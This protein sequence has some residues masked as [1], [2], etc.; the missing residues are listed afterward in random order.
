MARVRTFI[1]LLARTL[2]LAHCVLGEEK[3]TNV[4]K[5]QC[6]GLCLDPSVLQKGSELDGEKEALNKDEVIPS[7]T[8]SNNFINYC[9]GKTLTN[10]TKINEGSCN[11]IP[12]GEIPSTKH[13]VST[14]I[15]SPLPGDEFKVN[16]TIT[17][18]V[19]VKNIEMGFYTNSNVSFL[20]APQSLNC[21]GFVRGHTHLTVQFMGLNT[22]AIQAL[23]ASNPTW[24]KS[25]NG[26]H[27]ENK[28][29]DF[30]ATLEGGL[31]KPGFY[32]VCT[33]T[34]AANHQPVIMPVPNRGAQDDCT[35]FKV[36]SG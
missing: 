30:T 16:Q 32:R 19:A 18:K 1:Y 29:D 26:P 5:N 13:M 24:F 15:T 23:D 28:T 2:C 8:S 31:G 34:A 21:E 7:I 22:T 11:G 14:L 25:V 17:F 36:I 20:S 33:L 9:N 12:M 27:A 6:S 10:G 3:Q 4:P 35:K